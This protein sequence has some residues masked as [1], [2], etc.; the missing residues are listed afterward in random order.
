MSIL[1]TVTVVAVVDHFEKIIE[2]F[3][4]LERAKQIF[5]MSDVIL[6]INIP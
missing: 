1:S 6:I 4:I 3:I 5:L 2:D